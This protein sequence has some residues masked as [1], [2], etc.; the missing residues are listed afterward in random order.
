MSVSLAAESA[1]D[2]DNIPVSDILLPP[3]DV[4]CSYAGDITD[5][6]YSMGLALFLAAEVQHKVVLLRLSFQPMYLYDVTLVL[7]HWPHTDA[8]RDV[9]IASSFILFFQ[10]YFARL[11]HTVHVYSALTIPHPMLNIS[12]GVRWR[13]R[14]IALKVFHLFVFIPLLRICV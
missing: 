5:V 7:K 8:I 12:Y 6:Q 13:Y 4:A 10:L 2:A 1:C 3:A 14:R 9:K 11:C